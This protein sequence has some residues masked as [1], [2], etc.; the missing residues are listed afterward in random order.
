MHGSRSTHSLTNE[1]DLLKPLLH[2]YH[3]TRQLG[4]VSFAEWLNGFSS[5][6]LM[7]KTTLGW[8]E[9]NSAK[10][11]GARV[12]EVNANYDGL[13]TSGELVRGIASSLLG[14]GKVLRDIGLD[15]ASVVLSESIGTANTHM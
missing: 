14:I 5:R 12:E 9:M 8:V 3:R 7:Q 15:G 2:L 10:R 4:V 11:H 13:K 6:R 1:P